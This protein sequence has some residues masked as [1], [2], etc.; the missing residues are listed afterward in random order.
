MRLLLLANPPSVSSLLFCT[1]PARHLPV[2]PPLNYILT[3]DVP[4]CS[5]NT[6][7]WECLGRVGSYQTQSERC[8]ALLGGREW[9][10]PLPPTTLSTKH[11]YMQHLTTE[12][13]N[14]VLLEL[15]M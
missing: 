4:L 3:S 12:L 14:A 8:S 15:K 9:F 2:L 5:Y 1:A 13:I 7:L 6:M 11:N 10:S